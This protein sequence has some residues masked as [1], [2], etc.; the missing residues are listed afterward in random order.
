MAILGMGE[1]HEARLVNTPCFSHHF[2]R[3]FTCLFLA[4]ARPARETP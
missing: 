3:P 2:A 1:A 4:D